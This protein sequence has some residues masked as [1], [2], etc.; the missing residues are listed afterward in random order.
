MSVKKLFKK[1]VDFLNSFF[2]SPF[3]AALKFSLLYY[4]LCPRGQTLIQ[5]PHTAPRP[6]C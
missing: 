4:F 6:I 3:S 1:S 5:I 2:T